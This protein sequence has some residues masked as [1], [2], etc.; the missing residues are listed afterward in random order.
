M[1]TW[2][3]HPV[4]LADLVKSLSGV[5]LKRGAFVKMDGDRELASIHLNDRR[6]RPKQLL[7][8]GEVLDSQSSRHDQQLH[9]NAFLQRVGQLCLI[10]PKQ[11][12]FFWTLNHLRHQTIVPYFWAGRF[13]TTAQWEYLCKH[14]SHVLHRWLSHCISAA[15]SPVRHNTM[16]KEIFIMNTFNTVKCI[17]TLTI[18]HKLKWA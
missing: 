7:V 2:R 12:L 16:F 15:G 17:L 18:L 5:I 8:F 4:D 3:Q 14:S 1:L 6:R 9:G 10:K 13:E 11:W